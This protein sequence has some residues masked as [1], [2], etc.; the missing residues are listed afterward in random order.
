MRNRLTVLIVIGLVA[1]VATGLI[2]HAT[3]PADAAKTAVD[4]FDTVAHLFLNLIKM[5]IAPLIF[6][7]IVTGITGMTKSTG[8]GP[9]FAKA[10]TWFL[11]ASVIAGAWGFI[12][13]HILNV[14]KGLDL[15]ESNS[16]A[17]DSLAAKPLD[18]LTFIEH[19]APKSLIQA[20][21]DNNALQILVFGTLFGAALLALKRAGNT[22][23]SDV[24]EE[25]VPVML[26]LTGYVMRAAP[27][28]IFAAVGSAF[29][30]QGID[31][32]TT[33]AGLVGGYYASLG[34][35]WV[36]M[37]AVGFLFLGKSV[38]RLIGAIREPMVIAF[39]TA[40]SEAAFPKLI[41]AITRFGVPRRTTG[42][43]LPMG[44]SFNLDGSMMYMTFASVFLI[45]AYGISIDIGQ[46][47][48]MIVLLLVSSKGMAGVPRG[49]LV[50]LAAVLPS[51]GIPAAGIAVLLVVDQ[52]LDMGRT[53]TNTLGNAIATVVIGR[54]EDD[55]TEF[56]EDEA[57]DC[58]DHEELALTA[59]H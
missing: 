2:F 4:V 48:A 12:T 53:A 54:K 1:G 7:I 34:G 16:S 31:G 52:I 26:K 55:T 43:V 33:Y 29:T 11:A 50:I 58:K 27:V 23:I 51:F 22:K 15:P 39:S 46:Q 36:L 10:I 41:D 32:F 9:L 13:A 59:K 8:L 45:N 47:I 28:G 19:I 17:V 35:L 3:L 20:M 5:V 57:P 24:I 30:A 25:L 14:G 21:A 40:S 37:L 18:F 42:F 49:A 38:F 6:A 56:T 44:Y